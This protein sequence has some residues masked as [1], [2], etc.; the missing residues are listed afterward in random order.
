MNANRPL[1]ISPLDHHK[2]QAKQYL[3]WHRE[4]Y[5]PVAMLIREKLPRFHRMSDQEILRASFRLSDAQD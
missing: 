5:F 1:A 2:K 4:G 3:R